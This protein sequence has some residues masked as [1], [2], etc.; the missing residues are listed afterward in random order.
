MAI[1]DRR[2]VRAELRSLRVKSASSL[3]RKAKANGWSPEDAVNHCGDLVGAR[4]VCNNVEDAFRFVELL[5]ERLPFRSGHLV[6]Q[7]KISEPSTSGYRAIHLNF[8][9]DVGGAWEPDMIGCE[10]QIRSR[11]QDAW[12]ELSHD[13]IYKQRQIPQDLRARA[14]DLAEVLA[15]ADKI[16]SGIRLRVASEAGSREARPRLDQISAAALAHIFRQV[17]G[18]SPAEYAIREGMKLCGRIGLRSLESLPDILMRSGFRTELDDVY[19]KTLGFFGLSREEL[20]LASIY[21]LARGDQRAIARV[22]RRAREEADELDAIAKREALSSLPDSIDELI[23]QLEDYSREIDF[24][25]LAQTL[26]ATDECSVCG[27]TVVLPEEFAEAVI[28]HYG[29]PEA[30]EDDVRNRIENAIYHSSAETGGG[31]GGGSLC[32]YHRAQAE[33]DD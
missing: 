30:D 2:L 17:F 7:D 1:E 8:S 33:K 10:V 15:A 9:I 19:R 22:Q 21:A 28:V 3:S 27:E 6:V 25:E 31:P 23:E 14:A 13:D 20:F 24:A 18:R 16:A 12:A 5:K 4:V 32:S 11:L 26:D 29:V